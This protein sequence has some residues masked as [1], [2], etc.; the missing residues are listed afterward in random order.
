MVQAG[1]LQTIESGVVICSYLT[2]PWK[3]KRGSLELCC[4]CSWSWNLRSI[5]KK[6]DEGK[7]GGALSGCSFLVPN[8]SSAYNR[9]VDSIIIY[10]EKKKSKES[11]VRETREERGRERER[12]RVREKRRTHLCL[13]WSQAS[14]MNQIVMWPQEEG[15]QLDLDHAN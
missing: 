10:W 3:S 6:R 5:R 1:S 8:I 7:K 15:R 9:Q 4:T 11:S 12:E 13:A 2:E 14:K